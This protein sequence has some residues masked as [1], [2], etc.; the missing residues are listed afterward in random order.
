[1]GESDPHKNFI[2]GYSKTPNNVNNV[3][4]FFAFLSSFSSQELHIGT[5]K[6]WVVAFLS[7]VRSLFMGVKVSTFPKQTQQLSGSDTVFESNMMNTPK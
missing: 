1:D 6:E 5:F 3:I 2:T 4:K 7:L